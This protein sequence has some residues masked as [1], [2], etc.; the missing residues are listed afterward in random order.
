MDLDNKSGRVLYEADSKASLTTTV[1][2]MFIGN[3]GGSF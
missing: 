1:T 2:S 3:Q